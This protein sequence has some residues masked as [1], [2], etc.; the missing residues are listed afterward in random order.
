MLSNTET[1]PH[2][3]I[4][5]CTRKT[6]QQSVTSNPLT[7]QSGWQIEWSSFKQSFDRTEQQVK[8]NTTEQRRVL[9]T[10]QI[11]TIIA[12]DQPQQQEGLPFVS[13]CS[14]SSPKR[15]NI[16]HWNMSTQIWGVLKA[17]QL[18]VNNQSLNQIR[19]II[20]SGFQQ[21]KAW[22]CRIG[23]WNIQY[24]IRRAKTPQINSIIENGQTT[25]T[26]MHEGF[27][28]PLEYSSFHDYTEHVHTL[29]LRMQFII[30]NFHH[31]KPPIIRFPG[32]ACQRR[33]NPG[34]YSL[35]LDTEWR[36]SKGKWDDSVMS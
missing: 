1:C 32:G 21:R 24:E 10:A 6:I 17:Q 31:I 2:T 30:Q 8:I 3:G 20:W 11:S 35:K 26:G 23:H 9:S 18:D 4:W 28:S 22:L 15:K 12:T 14:I 19:T 27:I 36:H 16:E 34:V 33:C 7:Q 5:S 13:S 25:R 29:L